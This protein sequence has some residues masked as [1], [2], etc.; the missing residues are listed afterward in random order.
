MLHTHLS[1]REEGYEIICLFSKKGKSTINDFKSIIFTL[2]AIAVITWFSGET[3]RL[4]KMKEKVESPLKCHMWECDH[5]HIL[6]VWQQGLIISIKTK[7]SRRATLGIICSVYKININ[8]IP[9]RAIN[10]STLEWNKY[11]RISDWWDNFIEEELFQINIF[12]LQQ[13]SYI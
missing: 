3:E 2:C 9:Q 7:C 12:F 8:I 1:Q 11:V 6:L 13:V 4:R 5:L 10:K